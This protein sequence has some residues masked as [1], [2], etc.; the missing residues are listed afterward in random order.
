MFVLYITFPFLLC[1]SLFIPSL[2]LF[3]FSLISLDVVSSQAV[4]LTLIRCEQEHTF[5]ITFCIFITFIPLGDLGNWFDQGNEALET[6][7]A[8]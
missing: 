3:F 6:L 1:F 7:A 2:I 4:H 8:Q 5:L